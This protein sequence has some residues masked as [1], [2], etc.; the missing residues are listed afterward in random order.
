MSIRY[1]QWSP[2]IKVR[3]SFVPMYKCWTC[4]F[5]WIDITNEF[6]VEVEHRMRFAC[7]IVRIHSQTNWNMSNKLIKSRIESWLERLKKEN[8]WA[9]V[10]VR[11]FFLYQLYLQC[12]LLSYSTRSISIDYRNDIL[13]HENNW[14]V[15]SNKYD[16]DEEHYLGVTRR[17]HSFIWY[18]INYSEVVKT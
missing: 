1:L 16:T 11:L 6:V 14:S 9:S 2:L 15:V 7:R 10:N 13:A 12:T 17:F 8:E 18:L 3:L 5:R 4:D